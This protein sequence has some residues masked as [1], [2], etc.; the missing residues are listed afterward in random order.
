MPAWL[1][2]PNLLSLLRLALAPYV[3]VLVG[4]RRFQAALVLFAVAA[5][6]DGLDGY[7]ARRCR[8]RTRLGVFLD[9]A[10]DKVLLDTIYLGLAFADVLPFWLAWLVLGRDVLIVLAAVAGLLLTTC[11]Q[12]PP[13]VWGKLS[14]GIQILT[15]ACGLAASIFIFNG[16]YTLLACLVWLTAAATAWSGVH[17]A[18]LARHIWRAF[19]SMR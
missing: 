19:R 17:Y 18:W 4:T 13:S 6:T 7:L 9:P 14:T 11:R 2:P 16:L 8:W 12:F 1:N 15:A 5:L 10:A 3:F